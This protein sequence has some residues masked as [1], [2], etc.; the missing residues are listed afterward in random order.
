MPLLLHPTRG[1]AR[2][3]RLA[4][5][6]LSGLALAII[7]LG[8]LL[9][10]GS[11][12]RPYTIAETGQ[13]YGSLQQAVDAISDASGTIRI[14]AGRWRDCAV[15][16]KG[17]VA[18]VAE[19]PGQAALDGGVCEGKAAL[20]LRGRSARVDGLIFA[21]MRV[22][23]FNGAGIRLEHGDLAVS[24]SWFMDSNEGILTAEDPGGSILVEKSTFTRLGT[25]EGAGGC[26]HSLYI[27]N[28]G[29]LTVRRCRFEQGRGGHY[30]KSRAARI[31][32]TQSSFDDSRGK[33][34]NYMIDLPGGASGTIAENW[35]VQG[36]DKEN[37]SAFIAVAAEGKAHSSNGLTI[38]ANDARLAPNVDRTTTFVA[39]WS[40]DR[41]ALDE[42]R[43]GLGL[44]RYER[45]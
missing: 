7:P 10:Q 25:C 3:D 43:L 14:A 4:L 28:Y 45:R 36:A 2:N 20:V 44:K 19:V 38:V 34:T 31:E 39:D 40:G 15:Q 1:V 23:E 22:P 12:Q 6:L 27:G 35:F 17:S 9:A 18:F 5:L 16:T 41:L 37:Y 29:A 21:N 33:T 8:A 42:N 30:V 24:Q 32:I 13:S 26:A 11:P